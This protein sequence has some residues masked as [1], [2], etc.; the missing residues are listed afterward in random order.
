MLTTGSLNET[1]VYILQNIEH[2]VRQLSIHAR[3]HTNNN[4]LLSLL[5][6]NYF[7]LK[8]HARFTQRVKLYDMTALLN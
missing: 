7:Q 8:L 2:Y 5:N 6:N 3:M 4:R 1:W